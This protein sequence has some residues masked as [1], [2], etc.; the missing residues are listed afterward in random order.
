MMTSII[1]SRRYEAGVLGVKCLEER[2]RASQARQMAQQHDANAAEAVRDMAVILAEIAALESAQ[3][4][5][6]ALEAAQ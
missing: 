4:E 5:I 2:K 1:D 3:A 6:V